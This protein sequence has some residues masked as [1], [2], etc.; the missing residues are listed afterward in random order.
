MRLISG[1]C[2]AALLAVLCGCA[3]VP[4]ALLANPDKDIVLPS[5][6]PAGFRLSN[7]TVVWIDY[8]SLPVKYEYLVPKALKDVPASIETVK[9]VER[10][11]VVLVRMLQSNLPPGL[12]ESLKGAGVPEGNDYLIE[13]QAK[14]V[15]HFDDHLGT[16]VSINVQVKDRTGKAVWSTVIGARRPYSVIGIEFTNHDRAYIEFTLKQLMARLRKAELVA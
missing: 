4:V 12:E 14:D 2:G 6:E 10:S 11:A 8:S 1:I 16:M 13:L 5:I 7:A 15:T 3:A 9:S